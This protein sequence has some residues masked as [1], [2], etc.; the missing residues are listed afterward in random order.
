MRSGGSEVDR[1]SEPAKSK[2][3]VD[4]AEAEPK[5]AKVKIVERSKRELVWRPV[6]ARAA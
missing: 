5:F 4:R 3:S 6:G 2:R 1:E